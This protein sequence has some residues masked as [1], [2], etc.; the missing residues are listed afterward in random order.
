MT[1]EKSTSDAVVTF[2]DEDSPCILTKFTEMQSPPNLK[3]RPTSLL[4]SSSSPGKM[5]SS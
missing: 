1:D 5:V 2:A 4:Q 3:P